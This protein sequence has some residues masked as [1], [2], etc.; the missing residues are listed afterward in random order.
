MATTAH[1]E[2]QA[3]AEPQRFE[4]PD[5]ATEITI[6]RAVDC[7]WVIP[8][9][10]VSRRHAVLRRRGAEL[11]VEDL[12]SSN[13]TM[14]NG[15]RLTGPRALRDQDKLQLGAVEIRVVIPEPPMQSD[16]TVAL[17]AT[18]K[19]TPEPVAEQTRVRPPTPSAPAPAKPADAHSGR[20]ATETVPPRAAQPAAPPA[21][22]SRPPAASS[23]APPPPSAEITPPPRPSSP[24]APAVSPPPLA[25]TIAKPAPRAA[26]IAAPVPPSAAEVT[27][28]SM[29]ELA[30]IAAG[31]FLVV[32]GVG[33]LL[34]RFAF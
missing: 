13:G 14:V 26:M 23:A 30:I 3:G 1:F 24:P 12:G 21:P 7:Q 31:S 6:G 17:D 18:R 22:S 15:Q 16:A 4:M 25:A 19:M 28:P 10:A 34:I 29:V 32:F 2:I 33:A 27:G 20:T 9:G 8:S 11:V 5:A